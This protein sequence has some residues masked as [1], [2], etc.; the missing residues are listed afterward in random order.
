MQQG[1]DLGG[2]LTSMG[3][4][5]QP[6]NQQVTP[7]AEPISQISNEEGSTQEVVESTVDNNET[8]DVSDA[9]SGNTEQSNPVTQ[10]QGGT[11]VDDTPW[12]EK[13]DQATSTP[14]TQE[15]INTISA[16]SNAFGKEF[17]SFSEAE[18]EIRAVLS[19][20]AELEQKLSQINEKSQYATDELRLANELAQKGGDWKSYLKIQSVNY[21]TIPDEQLVLELQLRPSFG[22]NEEAMMKWLE[23]KS[24]YDIMLMAGQLRTNLKQQQNAEL[25]RIEDEAARKKYETDL[26]LRSAIDNT[27][28]L[29]G[30]QLTP[31]KKRDLFDSITSRNFLNEIFYNKDGSV[32]FKGMVEMAFLHKNIKEIMKHNVTKYTNQGRKEIMDEV[33][34][35]SRRANGQFVESNGGS[36]N[37]LDIFMNNLKGGN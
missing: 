35:P 31:S 27:N 2:I 33:S 32:N 20:K 5:S 21:D 19:Q 25:K 4:G 1:N 7:Q 37:P 6:E 9:A 13:D 17:K 8:L 22:E 23:S 14:T 28:E 36:K 30:M 24:E 11:T 12:W 3:Y 26:G 10:E 15:D 18:N 34:N 16:I 29:Y